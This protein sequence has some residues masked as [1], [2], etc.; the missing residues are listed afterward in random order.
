MDARME[1]HAGT[2]SSCWRLKQPDQALLGCCS[3]A[4][5]NAALQAHRVTMYS[6]MQ[7]LRQQLHL[8][9]HRQHRRLQQLL[10]EQQL[11]QQ[12][13]HDAALAAQIC[14]AKQQMSMLLEGVDDTV[15]LSMMLLRNT[16]HLVW[17]STCWL[18]GA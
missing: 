8:D 17:H 11:L 18:Q 1:L 2:A 14:P 6:Q 9:V 10:Q 5:Q 16:I 12:K 15:R 3:A 4:I 13:G 7:H